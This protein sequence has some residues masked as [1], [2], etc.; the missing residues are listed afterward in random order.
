VSAA[1]PDGAFRVEELLADVIARLIGDARHVAV[2]MASPIPGT[3]ALLARQRGR[4]RP[5]V[6]VLQGRTVFTDGGR[7]LFDCAGQGR[8][9][10][11]FL[12]GA[13]IDGQANINLV[14]TGDYRRP[15]VRFAG[16]FGSSYLAFVV[17]RLILF[18]L[19]HT[20]RTLVERVDFISAPGMS[21]PGTYRPGGP[22]AL[23]TGRCLF[24]FDR[25]RGR[26]RLES[27]HPGH[28]LEE[29]VAQTGFTFDIPDVV[30]TT[31]PPSAETLRLLRQVVAPEVAEAYPQF[32]ASVF[33][34]AA[35][36]E[37]PSP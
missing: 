17:P 27:L 23:I 25:R 29:V 14:C 5:M 7:E 20:P 33:G 18:R 34:I 16:S 26:F 21:P 15:Q 2:G 28:T 1:P 22:V 3:A 32:A 30:P 19:E 10:V 6:S 24:A 36:R 4:G 31:A 11:F 35:S 12:S 13:Q 9:D 37:V 8:L